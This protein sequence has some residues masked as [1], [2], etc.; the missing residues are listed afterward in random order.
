MSDFFFTSHTL[1]SHQIALASPSKIGGAVAM[2]HH[3]PFPH[4]PITAISCP[5]LLSK[6]PDPLRLPSK[7]GGIHR[8]PLNVINGL[9]P[10]PAP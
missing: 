8:L 3:A 5:A 2:R 7:V 6:M 10:F 4:L 9:P 1:F